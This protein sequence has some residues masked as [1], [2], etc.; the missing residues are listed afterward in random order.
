MCNVI[1]YGISQCLYDILQLFYDVVYVHFITIK[2]KYFSYK[3]YI[4]F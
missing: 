1:F 4:T 2:S 3:I